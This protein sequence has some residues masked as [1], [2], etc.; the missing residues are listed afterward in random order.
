MTYGIVIQSE[1]LDENYIPLA[2]KSDAA[3]KKA[4]QKYLSDNT[5]GNARVYCA[6]VKKDGTRGYINPDG[7]ASVTGLAYTA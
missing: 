6:F 3:A 4:T 2:A 1:N 5:C 7:S